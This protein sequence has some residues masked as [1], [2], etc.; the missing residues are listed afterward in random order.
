MKNGFDKN[1]KRATYQT[2]YPKEDGLLRLKN[3]KE[4]EAAFNRD[5]QHLKLSAEEKLIIF[6]YTRKY[7]RNIVFEKCSFYHLEYTEGISRL[8]FE[9]C[10]FNFCFLGSVIFNHS[11]FKNCVFIRTDFENTIFNDCTFNNCNFTDC[12][13]TNAE[14]NNTEINPDA[15]MGGITFP[16]YNSKGMTPIQKSNFQKEWLEIKLNLATELFRSNTAT[17]HSYYS[18]RGLYYLKL[19]KLKYQYDSIDF[20]R[21]FHDALLFISCI[22]ARINLLATKGGISLRRIVT[23]AIFIILVSNLFVK[24]FTAICYNGVPLYYDQSGSIITQ[25]FES[26]PYLI[27]LFLGFG[28]TNFQAPTYFDKCTLIFVATIGIFWYALLIPVLV[29]KV[30]R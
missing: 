1:Y 11:R 9:D 15:L 16:T 25:F 27:S 28:F 24:S 19:S 8:T 17:A 14:F 12:T 30:Y 10:T 7:V 21:A 5:E 6:E 22:G 18:D 23:T 2:S 26:V 29:R 4:L 3:N 13:A 20:R